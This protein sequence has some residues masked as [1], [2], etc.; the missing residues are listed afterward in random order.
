[1]DVLFLIGRI[2]FASMFIMAGVKSHLLN[3]KAA[4]AYAGAAGVPAAGLMVPLTGLMILAGGLMILLGIKPKIGAILVLVFLIPTTL[5][6]HRFWGLP[7]PQMAQM[8]QANFMKN[9][10]MAGAALMFLS[11]DRWPLSLWP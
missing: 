9:L 5:M 8:Q 2:L 10:S 1:M 11:I 3:A 4:T 7:D 6:M